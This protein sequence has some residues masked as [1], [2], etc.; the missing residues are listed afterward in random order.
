MFNDDLL[1]VLGS[2]FS[3]DEM[4][5]DILVLNES[6]IHSVFLRTEVS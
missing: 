6:I 1:K 5:D 4:D 3:D 2:L